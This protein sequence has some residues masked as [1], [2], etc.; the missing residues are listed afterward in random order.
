MK[1]KNI[2]KGVLVAMGEM[3]LKSEDVRAIFEKRLIANIFFNF[4]KAGVEY[5]PH[6]LRDRIYIETQNTKKAKEILSGV[7]GIA[8]VSECFLLK[9][10]G[11]EEFLEYVKENYNGWIKAKERFAIRVR[12]EAALKI[13]KD[14]FI[15]KMAKIIK[16]K[17]DLTK[18]NKTFFV[19]AKRAGWL[20]YFKKN[21]GAGGLP[22][23]SSGKVL[24]LM[25][26][27]IDSPVAAYLIARRGAEN[28]WL[29]FHSFPVVSRASI[30]KAEELA[31]IFLKFQ[32]KLK[33]YFVPFG[34]AQMEIKSVA[35][36]N[37][38]VLIYRRLMLGIAEKIAEA[39][40]C[41]A[42]V[43]GESL[44]Q[45]SS[46]TLP[47]MKIIEDIVKI[48]VLRPA[49]ALDKE[50]IIKIAENIGS[51]AASIK[52][53]EDCCTVF[54]AKHQTAQGDIGRVRE[55]EKKLNIEKIIIECIAGAEKKEY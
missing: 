45:V 51:F 46:Q 19:E 3:F 43:T 2:K 7:F 22:N 5:R 17:V 13:D 16:R 25:S 50:E 41:E 54:I 11:E 42:L 26:G 47:N 27:G 12:V 6:L 10:S 48:P 34:K 18:P 24:T 37:Y 35:I 40:N 36:G 28:I 33:V 44:G 21:K 39:E 49:I 55:I 31:K 32:P 4:K 9:N 52:P 1:D 20:L 38:R 53:Q 29:H 23:G 14:A 8:W 30:D 15:D